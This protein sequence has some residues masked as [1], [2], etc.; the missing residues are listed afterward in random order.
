MCA[1]VKKNA[2]KCIN[3]SVETDWILFLGNIDCFYTLSFRIFME[4]LAKLP[5]YVQNYH[6]NCNKLSFSFAFN[7]QWKRIFLSNFMVLNAWKVYHVKHWLQSIRLT[8][9]RFWPKISFKWY[10]SHQILRISFHPISLHSHDRRN[11]RTKNNSKSLLFLL[12]HHW[13]FYTHHFEIEFVSL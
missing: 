2:L 7:S 4:N 1:K 8:Q 13:C 5:K 9:I 11:S 10:F 12:H 6:S 3:G